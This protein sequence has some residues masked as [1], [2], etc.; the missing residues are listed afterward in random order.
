[1][2]LGRFGGS[3]YVQFHISQSFIAGYNETGKFAG[4]LS[5]Y[6]RKR[7]NKF[8]SAAAFERNVGICAE[9]V[10]L[11]GEDYPGWGLTTQ[12]IKD[13]VSHVPKHMR[14]ARDP[15]IPKFMTALQNKR[16][17][18]LEFVNREFGLDYPNR[19]NSLK[20]GIASSGLL[21]EARALIMR[22]S[23]KHS[24]FLFCCRAPLPPLPLSLHHLLQL[25]P[26]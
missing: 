11:Y 20:A 22:I 7:A 13:G 9:F 6:A 17:G 24:S 16:S 19:G 1:M 23:Q 8:S 2:Q 5:A 21:R 26:L 10:A 12:E 3:G 18:L 15:R 25:L 4:G 14:E